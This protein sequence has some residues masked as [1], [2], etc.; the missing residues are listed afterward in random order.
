MF[1]AHDA[2]GMKNAGD[3][4]Q[5]VLG[6]DD[7]THSSTDRPGL[8]RDEAEQ[9]IPDHIGHYRPLSLLGQGGMGAVY[10]AYDSRLERRVALK[11]LPDATALDPEAREL[12]R[13]EAYAIASLNH[14]GICTIH[15]IEQHHGRL[16]LVFEYID[17]T[18][19]RE[20]I[21]LPAAGWPPRPGVAAYYVLQAAEA[22]QAAHSAGVVHRDIKSANLILT[23][24]HRVKVLDFGGAQ[25]S[26]GAHLE[27]DQ[28]LIGTP[29]YLSPEQAR[30]ERL[31][32][33]T[34]LWSLGVVF[35]ELLTL[36]APFTG[37]SYNRL[38]EA[39][40]NDEPRPAR[41]LRPEISAPLV[42]ILHKLLRKD[43]EQRYP[44]ARALIQD[45][46]PLAQTPTGRIELRSHTAAADPKQLL[47][48]TRTELNTL[49]G[50]AERRSVT[51]LSVELVSGSETAALEIERAIE[52]AQELCRQVIESHEGSIESWR[53]NK[54]AAYFGYPR[55]R[56]DAARFAV[57]AAL[58][59]VEAFSRVSS[60]LHARVAVET[61]FIVATAAVSGTNAVLSGEGFAMSEKLS[62]VAGPNQVFVGPET[63]RLIEGR[64]ELGPEKQI[65][66]PDGRLLNYRQVLHQSTARSR[67]EA[68]DESSLTRL[69]GRDHELH[70]LLSRWRN[71][72]D[73]QGNVVLLAGEAGVGK[74]R[75]VYELKR[76]VAQDSSAALIECFCAPQYSGST[77]FPIVECFERLVFESDTRLL[78][79]EKK[80]RVLEGLLAELGFRLPETVPLFSQLLGI[81]APKYPPLESTPERQR[82]LT[83]EALLNIVIERAS[84][85]P[86][87]F[88]VEDLHWADPT[89][90]E[91]LNLIVDQAPAVRLL[92]LGTHRPERELDWAPRSYVSS[93]A[94][95]RLSRSDS[96]AVASAAARGE[97]LSPAVLDEIVANSDGVPLF[98]EEMTKT[99]ADAGSST[100]AP[101]KL[102]VPLSL[103]D[104]FIGRLDQLGPARNVARMAS[105]LGREFGQW[106]IEVVSGVPADE[107]QDSLRRLVEAEI[108]HVRGAGERRTYI[109]K[110]VLLQEAAYDSLVE[111]TRVALHGLV[112]E[113]LIERF[114]DIAERQPELVARHLTEARQSVRAIAY[115]HQAG[116]GALK[117]SA[118]SEAL[119]S[120][121][122]GLQLLEAIP[123]DERDLTQELLLVV[124]QGSALLAT[125]GFG[126]AEVGATYLRAER[127]LPAAGHSPLTLPTLW[128]VWVYSLV[129]SKLDHALAMAGKMIANG[130]RLGDDAMLLE[131]LWTEGNTRYWRGDLAGARESLERARSLYQAE[132]FGEHAFRFGQ[133][134]LVGTLCY[135]SF[136]YCFEGSFAQAIEAGDYAIEHARRLKH[137]FSIGWGLNF[138]AVLAYFLGDFPDALRWAQEGGEYCRK[139][140]YPFW[141]SAALSVI[142][143]SQAEAGQA[144]AGLL[145]LEEALG[146][147]SA[148]GS[149]VVEPLYRGLLAETHLLNGDSAGGLGE[150]EHALRLAEDRGIGASRLDL[151]RLRGCALAACGRAAEAGEALRFALEESRHTGCRLVELRTATDLALLTG[152]QD[153]LQTVCAHFPALGME[154]PVLAKARAILSARVN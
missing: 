49:V 17:G 34:D 128:G 52:E 120:F 137:P 132:R 117:R 99:V 9:T 27:G 91:L 104:S 115:W 125:R 51:F 59:V 38:R 136:V 111:E 66:L 54:A 100:S 82:T 119:S 108:L 43:R 21:D 55:A 150:A 76:M 133:D 129:R 32:A 103:R 140:A 81:P 116:M 15:G 28:F 61:S 12:L 24:D 8:E 152:D 126:S 67:F 50:A 90:L 142:G 130:E 121:G 74:S 2:I 122:R 1:D 109:F 56:E 95:D 145:Q 77:L 46:R 149:Q 106:L 23:P 72:L 153:A 65:P 85:Q 113:V 29:K 147:T 5:P 110:H 35:Y 22:L 144:S 94:L 102:P 75:L 105:V 71:A 98:I 39:I 135:L 69:V 36:K 151:L 3:L 64:F 60:V 14:P 101:G 6:A 33:R 143:R 70:Y 41:Q 16:C 25:V 48:S 96:L 30:G 20:L 107:L 134:S 93:I 138:R 78:T 44:S 139:Q 57:T 31:D 11:M 37:D 26:R 10:L 148:I 7:R 118:H 73:D 80:L 79:P 114:P 146:L 45:L 47:A 63:E 97:R 13:R 18:T 88:V 124:S 131:G 86:L 141:I 84:K 40:I 68:I 127:L 89:T 19:I 53:G 42:R 112:A 58:A 123:E 154:P 92:M 87:L 83:L 62:A 4:P